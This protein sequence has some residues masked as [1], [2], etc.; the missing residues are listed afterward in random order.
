[1][2][3]V[4][5]SCSMATRRTIRNW[6][7]RCLIRTVLRCSSA[8]PTSRSRAW[9]GDGQNPKAEA[10]SGHAARVLLPRLPV[11]AKRVSDRDTESEACVQ[12]GLDAIAVHIQADAP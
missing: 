3:G 2:K 4:V 12:A 7:T 5:A 1:M 8:T 11:Q 6:C 10:V 9:S